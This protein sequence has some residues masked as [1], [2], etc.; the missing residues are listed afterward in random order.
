[1]SIYSLEERIEIVTAYIKGMSSREIVDN[2]AAA[3]PQRPIP[4]KTTV[5]K[6]YHNFRRTGCV[7]FK[8]KNRARKSLVVTEEMKMNICM[9]VEDEGSM[10]LSQLSDQFNISRSSC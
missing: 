5:L 4:S 10:T 9:A 2:F 8:H 7:N 3:H 6:L 1:M